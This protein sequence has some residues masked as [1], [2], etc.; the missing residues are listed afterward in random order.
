ML[1]MRIQPLVP[2]HGRMDTG[3]YGVLTEVETLGPDL[4]EVA[5]SPQTANH[6]DQ[7]T[8]VHRDRR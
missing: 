6:R 5:S 4:L 7:A 2:N 3:L 1:A 8:T